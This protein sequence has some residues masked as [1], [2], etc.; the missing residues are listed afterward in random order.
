MTDQPRELAA[1]QTRSVT[2]SFW[3]AGA[4]PA[5]VVGGLVTLGSLTRGADA[6]VGAGLGTVLAI[7][8]LSV[9]VLVVRGTSTA[10]PPAVMAAALFGYLV[11]VVIL[12]LAWIMLAGQD[13]LSGVH[14][15]VALFATTTAWMVGQVRGVR[16]LRVLIFGGSAE[17]VDRSGDAAGRDGGT[18]P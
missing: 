2:G 15:G 13:W 16:R 1:E 3:S 17:P 9:P 7:L 12:A 18:G 11:L 8:A 14:L 6:V 10:S 4:V 5:A